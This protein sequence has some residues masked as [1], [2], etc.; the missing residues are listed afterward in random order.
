MRLM[1]NPLRASAFPGLFWR[2]LI[3][4]AMIAEGIVSTITLNTVSLGLSYAVV[5][6]AILSGEV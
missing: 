2:L 5:R 3:G 4:P 1:F 6:K